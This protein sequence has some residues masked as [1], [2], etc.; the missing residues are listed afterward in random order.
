MT[1]PGTGG[2]AASAAAA[3]AAAA[4]SAASAMPA[5]N[6]NGNKQL[7]NEF[8]ISNESQHNTLTFVQCCCCS[9]GCLWK[10]TARLLLLSWCP[11]YWPIL[12]SNSAIE[13]CK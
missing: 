6:Q 2:L 7:E 4:A 11:F 13:T 8:K 9:S 12:V 1:A 5:F 3:A 10:P